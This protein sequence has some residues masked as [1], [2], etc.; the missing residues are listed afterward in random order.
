MT[1]GKSYQISEELFLKLLKYH[2]FNQEELGA[3]IKLGLEEKLEQ[4]TRHDMY[5]RYK[6]AG[7]E[8]DREK[9][10][11]EYLERV[12]ISDSFRR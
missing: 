2:L 6:T 11:Q 12:G 4:I 7:T 8:E 5:S 3:E 9:A 1:R 10:R